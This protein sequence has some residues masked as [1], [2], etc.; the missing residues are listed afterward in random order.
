MSLVPL[1]D[2]LRE[3]DIQA[4]PGAILA[5]K[6]D[7]LTRVATVWTTVPISW[8][9]PTARV[10][11]VDAERW[12]W[13]WD[14]V[15]YDLKRAAA[16]AGM[17]PRLFNYRLGQLAGVRLARPDGTLDRKAQAHLEGLAI[18]AGLPGREA[19]LRSHQVARQIREERSGR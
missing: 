15:K 9:P 7:K 12:H 10:P 14:G 13:M 8:K 2:L 1:R 18:T 16:V 4:D 11:E 5:L 6:D 3:F 19:A 17:T